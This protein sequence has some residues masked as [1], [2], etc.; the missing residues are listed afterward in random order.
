MKN[1]PW[2]S[3]GIIGAAL[4]TLAVPLVGVLVMG[5]ALYCLIRFGHAEAHFESWD[6]WL[7][8]KEFYSHTLEANKM[9]SEYF[10]G[11]Q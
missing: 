11:E 5:L 1:L 6:Y 4:Y 8:N 10:N 7:T 9:I 3:F 2:A